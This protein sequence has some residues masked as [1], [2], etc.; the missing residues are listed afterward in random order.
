MQNIALVQNLQSLDH[1]D[2]DSPNIVFLHVDLLFLVPHY[3][4]VEVTVV[5]KLHHNTIEAKTFAKCYIVCR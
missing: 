4:L 2:E 5:C 1:L 3:T